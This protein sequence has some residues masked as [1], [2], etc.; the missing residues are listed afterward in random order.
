LYNL[1]L[2]MCRQPSISTLF[3]YTT[4][5]R[6]RDYHY[7]KQ[8]EKH[9]RPFESHSFEILMVH[10]DPRLRVLRW[11]EKLLNPLFYSLGAVWVVGLK[12][13]K[14]TRLNS[15]TLESRMPSSA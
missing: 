3:P 9:Y 6:S 12:D 11:L 10:V 8:E 14:S 4:L 2:S 15:V 1:F 5:F 13:R 7:K